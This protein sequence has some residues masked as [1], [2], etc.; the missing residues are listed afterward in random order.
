MMW[1]LQQITIL[2][3]NFKIVGT[4]HTFRKFFLTPNSRYLIFTSK[5]ND[6]KVQVCLISLQA[7]NMS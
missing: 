5:I 7:K 4:T 1:E 3:T 6:L 2:Q